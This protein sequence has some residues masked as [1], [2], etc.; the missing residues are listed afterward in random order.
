MQVR[1]HG[2]DRLLDF[3]YS[4]QECGDDDCHDAYAAWDEPNGQ[5]LHDP[6]FCMISSVP[7]DFPESKE[8]R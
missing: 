7:R 5:K 4:S 3:F 8:S 1:H 6:E 2:D